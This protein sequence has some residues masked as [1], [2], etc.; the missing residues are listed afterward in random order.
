MGVDR[1]F[2]PG[3]TFAVCFVRIMYVWS[4]IFRAG[5]EIE[6]EANVVIRISLI[7]VMGLI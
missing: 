2:S 3:V 7:S 5:I 4:K 6:G 1:C